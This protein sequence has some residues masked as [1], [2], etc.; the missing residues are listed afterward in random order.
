MRYA[1]QGYELTVTIPEDPVGSAIVP[2]LRAA[3]EQA[4]AQRY[5]YADVK[6]AVELV[7]V[8][9]TAIGAG[10]EV[11]LP[12]HRSGTRLP[13]EARKADRPVYFPERGGYAP[14]PTYERSRL[15]VGGRIAGPAV[16]EEPE[17]TTV[18]PPGATAEVDRWANLIVTL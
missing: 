12:E 16:V 8:G 11:R 14:C 10:P 17:S 1:G 15:P 18:L 2:A 3:F 7:T 5:G 4:Y 6:A 9:V 13:E